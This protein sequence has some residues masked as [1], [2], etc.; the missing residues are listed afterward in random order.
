MVKWTQMTH[1]WWQVVLA[2]TCEALEDVPAHIRRLF[3][4]EVRMGS[5]DDA[6]RAQLLQVSYC[7]P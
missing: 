1:A 6:S 7:W 4:H 2:A 5:L 3:S